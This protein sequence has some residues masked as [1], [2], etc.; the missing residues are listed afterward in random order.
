MVLSYLLSSGEQVGASLVVEVHGKRIVK[1]TQ[2]ACTAPERSTAIIKTS[3]ATSATTMCLLPI[4]T[5]I[6]T[7][8]FTGLERQKPTDNAT[9]VHNTELAHAI[10][11]AY[12]SARICGIGIG[13]ISV[14][15]HITDLSVDTT[16][17]APR[18]EAQRGS[19]RLGAAIKSRAVPLI[20]SG[21]HVS[22]ANIVV[23]LI[24]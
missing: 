8:L 19:S 3:A 10:T 18:A 11:T 14:V 6:T 20:T 22:N 13:R 7:S 2:I 21:S 23:H 17:A 1:L 24:S 9:E 15:Q 16:W 5:K 12:N 4:D